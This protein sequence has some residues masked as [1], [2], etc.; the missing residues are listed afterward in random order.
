MLQ[1]AFG[2]RLLPQLDVETMKSPETTILLMD[3]AIVPVLVRTTFLLLLVVPSACTPNVTLVVERL[4]IGKPCPV[5]VS[6]TLCGLALALSLKSSVPLRAPTAVGLKL[7]LM[8]QLV[9]AAKRDGQ[10]LVWRKS[11]VTLTPRKSGLVP[12][13]F[14][15]TG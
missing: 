1:L 14:A 8:V 6:V 13:F 10:L 7:T 5:P 2:A 4:A 9:P 11:P 3:S 15:I 12:V